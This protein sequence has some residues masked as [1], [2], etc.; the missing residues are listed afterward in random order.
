MSDIARWIA[1]APR[2]PAEMTAL[3]ALARRAR[4]M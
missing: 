2:W 3:R 1:A 4:V